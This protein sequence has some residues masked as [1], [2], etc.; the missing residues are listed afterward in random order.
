M[1]LAATEAAPPGPAW[2]PATTLSGRV[3]FGITAPQV[4]VD[5]AGDAIAAW[6]YNT[7]SDY[8]IRARF[9]RAGGTWERAVEWPGWAGS[10]SVAIDAEGDAVVAWS[11][12]TSTGAVA[13]AV[14]RSKRGRWSDPEAMSRPE[15][16]WINLDSV[17]VGM[18]ARGNATATWVSSN[19][20]IRSAYRPAG[21]AWL[22]PIQVT[23]LYGFESALR[24]SSS[25]RSL[26]IWSGFDDQDR[27]ARY[28][29][30]GQDGTW[31]APVLVAAARTPASEFPAPASAAIDA[32]G[33]AVI[34]W[35]DSEHGNDI[36]SAAYRTAGASGW[37]VTWDVSFA[38]GNARHP[39]V[40]M[41]GAGNAVAVWHASVDVEGA[42]RPAGR[43]GWERPV[44]VGTT[45]GMPLLDVSAR[46]EAVAVWE[47][48]ADGTLAASLR[49]P[50]T[51]PWVPGPAS[52]PAVG[53][54]GDLALDGA[55]NALVTW[56]G[57]GGTGA[58]ARTLD[59]SGPVMTRM[60][61]PRQVYARERAAFSVEAVDAWSPLVHAP[62]WR[63]GDGGHAHGRTVK[64]AYARP[65]KYRL[66]VEAVDAAGHTSTRTATVSVKRARRSRAE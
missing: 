40:G 62:L 54:I 39:V 23:T 31:G 16:G 41:D 46:G 42:T 19:F 53:V 51:A 27:Y 14:S 64:H 43:S 55:G 6:S 59:V 47:S 35:Q 32:A 18:D 61:V 30:L 8:R 3:P 45:A 1:V 11:R 10:A 29:T 7:G 12:M 34:V 21:S 66:S 60:V 52:Q 49:S 20:G 65:G 13:E 63:F 37:E 25:G 2:T 5:P 17:G 24:V 38:D 58:W 56:D 28:A 15:D 36:V 9:R 33:D 44:V 57:G 48:E 50:G 4:A 22:A 26:L